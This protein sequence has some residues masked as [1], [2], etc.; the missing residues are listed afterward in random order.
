MTFRIRLE[1][2]RFFIYCQAVCLTYSSIIV[3]H[4][5]FVTIQYY[6]LINTRDTKPFCDFR[7]MLGKYRRQIIGTELT[8][9]AHTWQA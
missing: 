6:T 9:S 8:L 3:I 4:H 5:Q 2:S 1:H 7:H